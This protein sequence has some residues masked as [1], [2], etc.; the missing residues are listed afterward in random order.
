MPP[1][2]SDPPEGRRRATSEA[3]GISRNGA[4]GSMTIYGAIA[5]NRRPFPTLS[6]GKSSNPRIVFT[7]SGVPLS[8]HLLAPN[9]CASGRTGALKPLILL[10]FQFRQRKANGLKIRLQRSSAGSSP[11]A[12]IS[13]SY[14]GNE[15][16]FSRWGSD[17][18][19]FRSTFGPLLRFPSPS[20]GLGPC[21]GHS[22]SRTW[23]ARCRR[24]YGHAC[25]SEPTVSQLVSRTVSRASR[26]KAR[27][28]WMAFVSMKSTLAPAP[29]E[30]N[31]GQPHCG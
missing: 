19:H 1:P 29:G 4:T 12:D 24:S 11:A 26:A 16:S 31:G 25:G 8:Y 9:N 22:P 15:S 30:P 3:T 2:Q 23:R 28:V 21:E 6:A 14:E 10:G 18:V 7:R 5:G 27:A 17:S 20:G 13:T